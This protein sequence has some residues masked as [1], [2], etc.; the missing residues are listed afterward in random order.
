[1][2][3]PS[4]TVVVPALNEE[5]NLEATVKN[6]QETVPRYFS[7]WEILIFNDGS[8]DATGR[9]ADRLAKAEERIRVTHHETPRNLGG[10]YKEGIQKATKDFL[11]MIPGDNECGPEVM[12][13]IFELAGSADMI[14]PYTANM[15]V[16]PLGRRILS[17]FF[18]MLVNQIS[19]QRLRYYNGAVLHRTALLKPLAIKTDG[20]GYQAEILVKLLRQHRSYREVGTQITYRSLGRSKA[21]QIKSLL[22][23]ATFLANLAFAQRRT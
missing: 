14:V 15:Y 18:V 13:K 22:K 1:M 16:R 11:I 19:R 21:I 3:E 17:Y 9:I 4:I 8:S 23:M 5:L 2:G 20:F 7:D 12:T 6:I 10:C